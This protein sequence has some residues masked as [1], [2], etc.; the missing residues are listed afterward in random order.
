MI[1]RLDY[2]DREK[3]ARARKRMLKLDLRSRGINS[4]SILDVMGDILR[5]E[6]VP[7]SYKAHAYADEPLPIGCGQTISQPY[8]V[9]LMTQELQLKSD[10]EVLEI[11][12]GC[13]YQTAVLAQL[14]KKVYTIESLSQLSEA[15]QNLLARMGAD[16]VEFFVGDGSLGWPGQKKF[17]RI[18]I[19]AAVPQ[20]PE[21]LLAQ[22]KV[23]GLIIAPV[24]GSSS[25]QLIV[26]QKKTVGFVERS[27]CQVRFVK[28]IGEQGFKENQ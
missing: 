11:G 22:L 12:T 24:G 23:G 8:I 25:Q 13:G 1:R 14:A 2:G 27:L 20:I 9:A 3:Y 15:A 26:S 17:D 18:I 4:S 21:A 19:T 10:C 6:F 28:L 16:N 5:E 7:Q